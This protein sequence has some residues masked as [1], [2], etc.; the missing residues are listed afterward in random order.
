M[1]LFKTVNLLTFDGFCLREQYLKQARSLI[2]K[3]MSQS[4][5]HNFSLLIPVFRVL[6]QKKISNTVQNHI[7]KKGT[8]SKVQYQVDLH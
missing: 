1:L 3:I 8:F 2:R 5:M 4:R 6:P 7:P